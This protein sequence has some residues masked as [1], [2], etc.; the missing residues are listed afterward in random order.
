MSS[1]PPDVEDNA[2]Q[3]QRRRDMKRLPA[4][5]FTACIGLVSFFNVAGNDRFETYHTLDVIRL[6]TAGAAIPVTIMLLIM[7]F[8]SSRSTANN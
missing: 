3:E 4:A 2:K 6:M 5:I 7:F 1:I 8:K